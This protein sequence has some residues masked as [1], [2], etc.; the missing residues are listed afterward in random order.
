MYTAEDARRKDHDELDSRIA[1]AVKHNRHGDGAYL[2][3]YIEDW[4]V[5]SIEWELEKRGFTNIEVPN[6]ILTADVYF[7][8]AREDRP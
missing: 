4:F 3:I 7:E 1:H 5:D 6:M 8:W 2:R